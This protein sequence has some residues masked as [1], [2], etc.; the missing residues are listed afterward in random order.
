MLDTDVV[1]FKL[2][3]SESQSERLSEDR[4]RVTIR[5][6]VELFDRVISVITPTS[7]SM[8]CLHFLNFRC[9]N[10]EDLLLRLLLVDTNSDPR[11]YEGL[12]IMTSEAPFNFHCVVSFL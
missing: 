9:T 4:S 5:K 8:D 3:T 7:T 6:T 10:L 1:W 2:V 12:P 11:A